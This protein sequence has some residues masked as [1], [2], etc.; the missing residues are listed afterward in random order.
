MSDEA[1]LTAIRHELPATTESVYLNTGTCGPLPRRTVAAIQA[2]I[3]H[4]LLHGRIAF[5]DFERLLAMI[6]DL[7]AAFGRLLGADPAELALTHHTSEGM[8][9]GTWALNWRPGDEL[10][11]TTLEHE[12]GLMP[13]YVLGRRLGVTVKVVELGVGQD[14]V[15]GRLEAAVTSRTRLISVS[16]VS[17]IS[18][19]KLPLAEIVEMAH[20]RGVLVLVDGAQSAGAMPI[21]LHA[22]GV[23]L[24]AVPG[25]KWLCGPEG[26]GALY[27][28]R[29]RLS[30]VQPTFTGFASLWPAMAIDTTGEYMLTADARRYEVGTV[31]RPAIA[32]MRESLRWLEEGVGWDWIYSR[33][34]DLARQAAGMLAELPGVHVLTPPER[35][36]LISFRV[37]GWKPE[38][39][40]NQL[41]QHRIRIRSVHGLACL[42]VST[43]FYTTREDLL[44][45]RDRL[46]ETTR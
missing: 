44:Q 42:R 23:D 12:G 6:D 8:N 11:T 2:E 30:E 13:A 25:Q 24:Y 18:G 37:D 35:A 40:V 14:D 27:V 22:L 33:I 43:G 16:H 36:G 46:A 31:F 7:R 3:Q 5:A 41:A 21:D 28:R 26:V 38:D 19:A 34:A 1:K 45:L 10:I 20:R 32:G 15:V 29:D 4:E 9:I 39:V 17:F